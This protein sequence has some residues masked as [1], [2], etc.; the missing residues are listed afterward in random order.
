MTVKVTARE[1]YFLGFFGPFFDILTTLSPES[2]SE[3]AAF[4]LLPDKKLRNFSRSLFF[5]S[6]SYRSPLFSLFVSVATVE[7]VVAVVVNTSS[8]YHHHS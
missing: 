7:A 6:I 4:L 8:Y 5:W 1:I 3:G 2:P